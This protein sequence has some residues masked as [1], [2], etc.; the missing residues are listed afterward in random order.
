MKFKLKD[1]QPNPFRDLI[2]NPLIPE[3]VESFVGKI[4]ETGLWPVIEARVRKDGKPEIVY[5]HHRLAAARELFP[6]TQEVELVVGEFSD[7][8]MIQKMAMENCQEYGKTVQVIMEAIRATVK[9]LSENR[10]TAKNMPLHKADANHIRYAPSFLSGGKDNGHGYTTMSLATFL[11]MV[12]GKAMRTAASAENSDSNR[13]KPQDRFVG[14][15]GALELVEK[16]LMS[17]G[18]LIG[19]GTEHLYNLVNVLKEKEKENAATAKELEEQ[20]AT[21]TPLVA[22]KL[23]SKATKTRVALKQSSSKLFRMVKT[24][25]IK[26]SND[27]KKAG[28]KLLKINKTAGALKTKKRP[29]KLSLEAKVHRFFDMLSFAVMKEAWKAQAALYHPDRGGD[30]EIATE[31]NSLWEDLKKEYGK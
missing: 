5:G 10:I 1:V 8:D 31:F 3:T 21:A 2:R 16:G 26:T 27:I 15:L 19:I 18:D 6:G 30:P 12:K 4:S 25:K 7:A 13:Q 11:G 20:A 28:E 9:A 23:R 17:E 22:K 29:K 14:C 24:K